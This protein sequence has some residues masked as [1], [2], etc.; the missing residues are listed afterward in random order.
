MEETTLRELV[1]VQSV[2]KSNNVFH[3][4][5]L[6][7]LQPNMTTFFKCFMELDKAN[8]VTIFAFDSRIVREL[9]GNEEKN[10]H[11]YPIFYK[12]KQ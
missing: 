10:T 9:I 8:L 12:I 1:F 11:T 6:I 7:K 3:L 4:I 2:F 5:D